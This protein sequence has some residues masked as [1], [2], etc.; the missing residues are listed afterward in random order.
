MIWDLRFRTWGLE[1]NF[2]NAHNFMWQGCVFLS[3]LSCKFDDRFSSNFHRF[4][5]SCNSVEICQLWRL[6]FENY[7]QCPVSLIRNFLKKIA[8][9]IIHRVKILIWKNSLWC[10]TMPSLHKYYTCRI[11]FLLLL[12]TSLNNLPLFVIQAEPSS[13]FLV[14]AR[15]QHLSFL[16]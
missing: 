12:F 13:S 3:L 2:L 14:E 7:Q 11:D 9:I 6:V 5:I 10:D 8:N 1:I 4:V 15:S 16:R